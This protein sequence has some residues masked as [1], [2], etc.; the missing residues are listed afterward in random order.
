MWWLIIKNELTVKN[1]PNRIQA[2]R[3]LDNIEQT[4]G[5]FWRIGN[6]FF[7][8]KIAS[9]KD[10]G[11]CFGLVDYYLPKPPKIISKLIRTANLL[12]LYS[13]EKLERSSNQHSLNALNAYFLVIYFTL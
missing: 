2:N 3:R 12:A 1:I 7:T 6:V 8:R 4:V 9:N 13:Y 5:I 10:N 11:C